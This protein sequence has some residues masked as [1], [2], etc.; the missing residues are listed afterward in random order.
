MPG[1]VHDN[2]TWPSPAVAKRSVGASGGTTA[3]VASTG[4]SDTGPGPAS[5]TADTRNSYDSPLAS[6]VTVADSNTDVPSSN[7]VH[8]SSPTTE[9]STS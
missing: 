8:K 2:P 7:V 9:Y 5:L 1:A 6:P 3:S 4:G